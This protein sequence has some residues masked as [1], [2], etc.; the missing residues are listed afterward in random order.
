VL[1]TNGKKKKAYSTLTECAQEQYEQQN[2]QEQQ[3]LLQ[4]QWGHVQQQQQRKLTD[5][6]HIPASLWASL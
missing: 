3:Q 6:S 1:V 2:A 4:Q 5:T